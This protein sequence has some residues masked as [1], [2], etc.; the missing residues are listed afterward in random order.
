MPVILALGWLR[1]VQ[2][3]SQ[4]TTNKLKLTYK[5]KKTIPNYILNL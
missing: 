1:Q 4:K 3:Q 5:E 2:V